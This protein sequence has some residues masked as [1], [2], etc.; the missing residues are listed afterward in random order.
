MKT[1]LLIL[2]GAALLAFA[3]IWYILFTSEDGYQDDD[4]YHS[5]KEDDNK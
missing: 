2:L 3:T 4:G 1:T 5:G